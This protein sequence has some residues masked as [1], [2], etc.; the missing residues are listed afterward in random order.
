M[1]ASPITTSPMPIS[2]LPSES[3]SGTETEGNGSSRPQPIR[4]TGGLGAPAPT[5]MWAVYPKRGTNSPQPGDSATEKAADE[6][7]AAF[8]HTKGRSVEFGEV[9][10]AANKAGN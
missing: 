5:A 2:T 6:A 8:V 4:L 10:E 9:N 3:D 1:S 7:T